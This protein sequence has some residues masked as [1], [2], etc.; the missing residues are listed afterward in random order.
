MA[1]HAACLPGLFSTLAVKRSHGVSNALSELSA[2]LLRSQPSPQSCVK[3]LRA[4]AVMRSH[5]HSTRSHHRNFVLLQQR[6]VRGAGV[7]QTATLPEL[8]VQASRNVCNG[9]FPSGTLVA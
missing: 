8:D 6:G 9:T 5:A 3:G 2:N 7:Q 1:L 4:S